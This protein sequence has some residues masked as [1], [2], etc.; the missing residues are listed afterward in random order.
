MSSLVEIPIGQVLRR[1]AAVLHADV[2]PLR[3]TGSAHVHLKPIAQHHAVDHARSRQE[4]EARYEQGGRD[5][6]T[7]EKPPCD[8]EADPGA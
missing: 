8:D 1:N 6:R 5:G 7:G 4:D 2:A 3:G